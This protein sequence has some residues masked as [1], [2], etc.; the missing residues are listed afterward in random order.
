M[1]A[2]NS[3]QGYQHIWLIIKR[4][5]LQLVFQVRKKVITL[6][7]QRTILSRVNDEAEV[8]ELFEE[9]TLESC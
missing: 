2:S 8:V 1:N 9:F 7:V 4:S 6:T 3:C 5:I